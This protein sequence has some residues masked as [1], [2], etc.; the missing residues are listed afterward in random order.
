[1]V[2]ADLGSATPVMLDVRLIKKL[3]SSEESLHMCTPSYRPPDVCLG[4]RRFGEDLDVWSLGVVAVEAVL[5]KPLFPGDAFSNG[6]TASGKVILEEIRALLG[7]PAPNSEVDQWLQSLPFF[8]KFYGRQVAAAWHTEAAAA[9]AAWPPP[10]LVIF[11]PDLA[12][13]A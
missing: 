13:F 1:M 4:H 7:P 11:S 10:E 3:R 2:L 6:G 5:R 12:D 9:S 8:S